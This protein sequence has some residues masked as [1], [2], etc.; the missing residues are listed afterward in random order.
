MKEKRDFAKFW[1]SENFLP[2]SIVCITTVCKN[3]VIL[4]GNGNTYNLQKLTGIIL[5]VN[6][7][8]SYS[9]ILLL[10]LK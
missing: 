4:R 9:F 10:I 5:A 2:C 8:Y 7:Y 3:A 1:I 6:L